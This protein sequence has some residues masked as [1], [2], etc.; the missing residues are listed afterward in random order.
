MRINWTAE[1]ITEFREWVPFTKAELARE[2][3]VT[4]H[5]LHRW[6]KG[7]R[8]PMPVYRRALNELATREDYEGAT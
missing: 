4:W 3:S 1:A 5:T 2:L 8:V 6:E 7:E